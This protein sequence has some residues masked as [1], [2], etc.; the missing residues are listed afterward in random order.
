[1]YYDG[2]LKAEFDGIWVPQVAEYI[3]LSTGITFSDEGD[4]RSQPADSHLSEA[5]VDY[6]RVWTLDK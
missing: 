4:F 2:E 5:Y 6:V 1:M 3:E